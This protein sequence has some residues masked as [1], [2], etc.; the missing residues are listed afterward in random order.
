M[1]HGFSWSR[2]DSSLFVF[3]RDSCILYLLVYVDD[4]IVTSLGDVIVL[5]FIAWLHAEFRI[6][7][8]GRLNYFLGLEATH[9]PTGLFLSQEKYAHDIV[10]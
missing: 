1:H 8:L 5:S 4:L 6:K 3:H 9:H 10:S 2:A 7:G